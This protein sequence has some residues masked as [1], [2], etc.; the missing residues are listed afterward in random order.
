MA[1]DLYDTHAIIHAEVQYHWRKFFHDAKNVFRDVYVIKGNHDAPG[2]AGSVATALWAHVDQAH[3]VMDGPLL[4][5]ENRVLFCPYTSGDQLVAWAKAHA[6]VA[7]ILFC[8]QTFDGSRY[9]NGFY[10]GDGVDPELIPQETVISGHIHLPQRF[11]K[12]WY[13]GAPRWRHLSDA[14]VDRALWTLEIEAGKL[15]SKTPHPTGDVCRRIWRFEDKPD[16]PAD[17]TRVFDAKDTVHVEI[18]GPKAWIDAR[19]PLW[20]GRARVQTVRTD[21]QVEIAVR[22]SEGLAVAFDKWIDGFCPPRGTDRDTLR[23]MAK[24]RVHGVV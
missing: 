14:N 5:P 22:E 8:H 23:Q 21:T 2:A 9:D 24:E 17:A 7:D 18:V 19:Q 1:G 11:G 20:E 4:M 6:E 15:V 13:P 16:D 12:V 3:C 10:A